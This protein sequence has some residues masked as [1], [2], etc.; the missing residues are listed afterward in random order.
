MDL[1]FRRQPS[2]LSGRMPN[3]SEL[4][5]SRAGL[6]LHTVHSPL[7]TIHYSFVSH[8]FRPANWRKT[9]PKT[10]KKPVMLNSNRRCS[11][12][13]VDHAHPYSFFFFREESTFNS[14]G[15]WASLLTAGTRCVLR[16]A[17]HCPLSTINLSLRSSFVLP[18][19]FARTA[20]KR[21][22]KYG[23]HELNSRLSPIFGGP[24]F[25]QQKALLQD[26][27]RL[28]EN[29]PVR[30]ILGARTEIFTLKY[31]LQ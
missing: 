10:R 5:C 23:S 9:A 26:G 22:A 14:S 18:R 19:G 31:S 20:A 28:S 6:M 4:L 8:S 13:S 21:H 12:R 11:S 17:T 30:S 29:A 7:P 16:S 15:L 2:D 1:D 24:V 25:W 3:A 27:S